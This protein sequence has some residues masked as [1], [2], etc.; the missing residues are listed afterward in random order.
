M[1]F[2][3]NL[4][5]LDIHTD[6][7]I[8]TQTS[9]CP[10]IISIKSSIQALQNLCFQSFPVFTLLSQV[11]SSFQQLTAKGLTTTN[12]DP[13]TIKRRT[14]VQLKWQR[15]CMLGRGWMEMTMERG[16]ERYGKKGMRR[17]GW[18]QCW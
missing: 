12:E 7:N 3:A 2:Q 9:S 16:D 18:G 14:V 6:T 1:F 15:Y 17:R 5:L 10:L 13:P 11:I 4:Y 8:P